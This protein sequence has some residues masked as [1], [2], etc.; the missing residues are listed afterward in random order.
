MEKK[1]ANKLKE[2]FI[3]SKEKDLQSEN[4]ELRT[5]LQELESQIE[6]MK[7]CDNCKSTKK[8]CDCFHFEKWKFRG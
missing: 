5:K 6:K 7:N 4:S 3:K 1:L 8:W 2:K